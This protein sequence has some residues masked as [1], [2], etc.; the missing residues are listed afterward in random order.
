MIIN[1]RTLNLLKGIYPPDTIGQNRG[2]CA[3]EQ[4]DHHIL[5]DS[6]AMPN[7]HWFGGTQ[8]STLLESQ[9]VS[10]IPY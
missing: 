5:K 6:C 8:E 4:D 9:S 3:P 2:S 10:I 1:T 7:D